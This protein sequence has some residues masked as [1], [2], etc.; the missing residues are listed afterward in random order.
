ML[1]SFA[2]SMPTKMPSATRAP[3]AFLLLARRVSLLRGF[4]LKFKES[5]LARY[6]SQIEPGTIDVRA[7]RENANAVLRSAIHGRSPLPVIA[8]VTR[9]VRCEGYC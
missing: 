2:S 4:R 9:E 8:V 6:P 1:Q 5:H 3:F 7:E